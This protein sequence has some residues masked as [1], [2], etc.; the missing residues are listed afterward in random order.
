[1]N[2]PTGPGLEGFV[3]GGQ[4]GGEID[5]VHAPLSTPDGIPPRIPA[6]RRFP[7]APRGAAA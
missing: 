2:V 3:E 1:L 6:F 4:L 5:G 7:V